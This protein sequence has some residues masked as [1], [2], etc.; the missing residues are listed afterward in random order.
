M[1][2]FVLLFHS[3]L[4]IRSISLGFCLGFLFQFII[5]FK[6]SKVSINLF[7][8]NVRN[9]PYKKILLQQSF[10]VTLSLLPFTILIPIAYFWASQLETG[11]ISYL[12]YS[13]SFAGFLSVAV[14]MGIAVVSLPELADKFANEDVDSEL[15]RFEKTLK[16]VLLIGMFIAGFL[17]TLRVPIISFFYERGSFDVDS[18]NNFS[19]VIPWYLLA[20]V[21]VGGLNILRN[22]FYS[23][24]E[25]RRIAILGLIM[26]VIFFV[27]AGILKNKFSFVGIGI[28]NALTYIILFFTSIHIAKNKDADF[29]TSNFILFIFKNVIAVIVSILSVSKFLPFILSTSSQ[30]ASITLCFLFFTALYILVLKFIFRLEEL[31]EIEKICINVMS[32]SNKL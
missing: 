7:S 31:D 12:G 20:G 23:K 5:L 4:Q 26:P 14:S 25:F 27:L 21:F 19:R 10:L 29:L 17:I 6:A 11:S 9:I 30:F 13:Q 1:I 22:L 2:C 32:S 16:Y 8:F 18:V 24:G 3:K 15:L 28:A